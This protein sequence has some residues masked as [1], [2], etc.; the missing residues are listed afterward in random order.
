MYFG[1]FDLHEGSSLCGESK[2]CYCL[3][4]KREFERPW[5][6]TCWN[7]KGERTIIRRFIVAFIL[8]ILSTPTLFSPDN[9]VLSF[10]QKLVGVIIR[11]DHREA[12]VFIKSGYNPRPG[13]PST[14]DLLA[15]FYTLQDLGVRAYSIKASSLTNATIM[16]KN[17]SKTKRTFSLEIESNSPFMIKKLQETQPDPS[18]LFLLEP[19][20]R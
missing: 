7:E 16:V 1:F 14:E 4:K 18:G 15:L 19:W 10:S 12:E 11:G 17:K 6:P 9:P 2:V 3:K 5:V 13:G 20:G 8:F